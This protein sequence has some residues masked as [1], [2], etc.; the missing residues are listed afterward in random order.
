LEVAGGARAPGRPSSANI[1]VRRLA[2]TDSISEITA[3]LH[4][5]Y[6][7]Q[8]AMGLS[9]LA[10][11]QDDKITR[12]RV[13]SGECWVAI[14]HIAQPDPEG[15]VLPHADHKIVGVILY[16]EIEDAEGPPWFHRR[17]VAWFSQFAVDPDYQ[18]AGLGGMLLATVERRAREDSAAELACSMAEPDVDLMN[19]YLRRGYRLVEHWQWPYTNYRSAILSKGV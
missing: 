9:P 6:A 3:L 15:G 12:Q 5:A 14:D 4:R 10:G 17:D 19:Y 16:H 11:R 2:P 13:F 18:G 8:M 1:I 7:K